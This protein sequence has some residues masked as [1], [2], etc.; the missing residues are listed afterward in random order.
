MIGEK[1]LYRARGSQCGHLLVGVCSVIA[2]YFPSGLT[3]F[4]CFLILRYVVFRVGY[5]RLLLIRRNASV[6]SGAIVGKLKKQKS[7]RH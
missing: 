3:T 2:G 4:V 6:G 7:F 5:E 1:C